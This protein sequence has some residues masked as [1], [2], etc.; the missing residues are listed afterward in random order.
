MIFRALF[1]A[2]VVNFFLVFFFFTTVMSTLTSLFD[3]RL[4]SYRFDFCN[5]QT[6]LPALRRLCENIPTLLRNSS[7]G[8]PSNRDFWPSSLWIAIP[9]PLWTSLLVSWFL[10]KKKKAKKLIVSISRRQINILLRNY[11]SREKSNAFEHVLSKNCVG[12]LRIVANNN[13]MLRN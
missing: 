11:Y 2:S 3:A 8:S 6:L 10:A 1:T 9:N 13:E 12:Q 4:R 7:H 5:P